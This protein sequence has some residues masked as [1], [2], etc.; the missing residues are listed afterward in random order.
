[1]K[2]YEQIYKEVGRWAKTNFGDNES[3]YFVLKIEAFPQ[4]WRPG[5]PMPHT[6]VAMESLC[7]LM[8]IAEELGEL[9]ASSEEDAIEDAIGDV[10]IYVCDY[11]YRVGFELPIGDNARP[12]IE[13]DNDSFLGLIAWVGKLFHGTL[14]RHEGIRGFDDD[15]KYRAH[16]EVCTAK[17]LTNLDQFAR[18]YG[19]DLLTIANKV[20]ADVSQRDWKASPVDGSVREAGN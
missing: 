12:D 14:K 2:S 17:I 1:M 18:E 4:G 6:L 9:A 15:A 7:P 16:C 10:F 3:P 20:W 19:F 13:C 5:H 8:G 11:A